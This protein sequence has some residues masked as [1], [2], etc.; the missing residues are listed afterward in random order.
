LGHTAGVPANGMGGLDGLQG[1][2][3]DLGL[4]DIQ[5]PEL[6]GLEATRRILRDVAPNIRPRIIA[7]SANALREDAEAALQAGVDDYVV[8]PIS[9]PML[10]AALERSGELAAARKGTSL[11]APLPASSA[12][13]LCDML[14]DEH[15]RSFIDLDPSGEIV[16]SQVKSLR[17]QPA[18]GPG[19]L[20]VNRLGQPSI[21]RRMADFLFFLISAACV[22]RLLTKDSE[23]ATVAVEPARW[24]RKWRRVM[25]EGMEKVMVEPRRE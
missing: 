19:G 5:M 22:R 16:A 14:D 10:R 9:V 15:L 6:D 23:A 2:R 25:P 18:Q 8:K 3:Y 12:D 20:A 21:Q 7:M 4:M 1:Q 24:L 11:P 13:M 17:R